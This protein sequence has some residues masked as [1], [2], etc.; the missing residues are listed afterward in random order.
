MSVLRLAIP[1]PLRRHFDY[2]PP[3]GMSAAEISALQPGVRLRVP[4]GRREVIG[5][6]L[7][8]CTESAIPSSSLK[9][10][11]EILDQSPLIDPHLLQLCLWAAN[12]YHHPLGD[13]YGNLFP[14]RLREGKP[15]SSLG[16]PGWQLTVRGKGLPQIPTP[17]TGHQ[18]APTNTCHRKFRVQ[19]S[20]Y[21]RRHFTQPAKQEP[22]R[23]LQY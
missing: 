5:Y 2:L 13:V 14:R 17:G 20:R 16:T 9:P 12:Y 22:D 18:L 19:E 8:V 10:V 4:F 1:S 11:L 15:H 3:S 23:N 21:Q 6:L 7:A